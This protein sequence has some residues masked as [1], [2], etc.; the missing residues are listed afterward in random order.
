[1]KIIGA[2]KAT[3]KAIDGDEAQIFLDRFHRSKA[4]KNPGNVNLGIF[5]DEELLGIAQFGY[6]RTRDKQLT[7]TSELYRLAFKKDVRIAGGASKLIKYYIEEYN[8]A[9]FFTYQ[10]TSGEAT[11]VYEHAGMTLVSQAKRKQYLV[12]P[13]KT[14]ETGSRK[15]VLGMPYATRYGP[16]RILGTKLGEVFREDGS[17][18]SNKELFLEDLGWHLEE[19]SG[20]RV[21]E[22]VNPNRTYYTY[23]I[24]ASNSDKYY[25]GVSHVKKANASLEDC[26]NDGYYGSGGTNE[27]NKFRRWKAKHSGFLVKNVLEV[28]SRKSVAYEREKELVGNLW[29][30][31]PLCLNSVAGGR[32][33]S[34]PAENSFRRQI[35]VGN[36]AEHGETKYI[37]NLCAKCRNRAYYEEKICPLHGTTI[38]WRDTCRKCMAKESFDEKDCKE[39]GL[40]IHHGDKCSKCA[41]KKR[42]ST[43]TCDL[44]GKTTFLGKTCHRCMTEGIISENLCSVHGLTKFRGRSCYKCMLK[45]RDEK[46][47]CPIHGLR[48]FRGGKCMS[49]IVENSF[50]LRECPLH[51]ITAFSGEKCKKC[52]AGASVTMLECDIHGKVKHKGISCAK[53]LVAARDSLKECVIHGAVKH[54]GDKCRKCSSELGAHRRFHQG[55]KK[56]NCRYCAD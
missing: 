15:E 31:D 50:E 28:F 13:G 46:K 10:D 38:F 55:N 23:K 4:L 16:D 17:R 43:S 32:R 3:V 39:H 51:G 30:I 42:F 7:Y 34:P 49:C 56:L 1:M 47:N 33:S 29:I 22:W 27:V 9:D 12:A 37:F 14:I 48:S 53:C 20:D 11:A 25:Y 24:M 45:K 41:A 6:P 36:C 54:S 44:H 40:T 35:T 21:Y 19:T 5:Y 26:L 18:K 8:P 52:S 2:R